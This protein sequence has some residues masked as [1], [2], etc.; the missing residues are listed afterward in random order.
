[1][2][3]EELETAAAEDDA[4]GAAIDVHVDGGSAAPVETLADGDG[5]GDALETPWVS[6]E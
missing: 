1:M 6:V 2:V 5:D 4:G 3:S